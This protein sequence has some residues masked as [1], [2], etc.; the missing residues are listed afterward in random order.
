MKIRGNWEDWED[1]EN[2]AKGGGAFK[3]AAWT[4]K[5]GK[6]PVRRAKRCLSVNGIVKRKPSWALSTLKIFL[7]RLRV[8]STRAAFSVMPKAVM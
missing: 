5:A 6:N 1:F 3:T 4:R 2:F 7:S 8:V